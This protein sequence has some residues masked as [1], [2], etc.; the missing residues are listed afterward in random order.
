MVWLPRRGG[1]EDNMLPVKEPVRELDSEWLSAV[2]E[3]KLD[4]G[5]CKP[6]AEQERWGVEEPDLCSTT[7][8][9]MDQ[10]RAIDLKGVWTQ[11]FL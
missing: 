11:P 7:S 10:R 1:T 5:L 2:T 9:K 4:R 3:S 8:S 6:A